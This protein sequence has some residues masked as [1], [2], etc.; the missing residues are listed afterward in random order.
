MKTPRLLPIPILLLVAFAILSVACGAIRQ[1]AQRQQKQN[2]LMQIGLA[3]QSYC[4]ANNK[5]PAGAD[6][7]SQY[8]GNAA[9]VQ[10]IKSGEYV[11]IWGVNLT[12]QKQF[13]QTGRSGTVLGYE[14][15]APTSG[16]VV[17][18]CD[19]FTQQMTAA[20]FNAKP[21]AKPGGGKK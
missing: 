12:D 9:V 3:Y 13:E 17:V 15:S 10:K 18:M 7:L 4:D 16:G 20:D 5:G 14:A 6:D 2:D 8:I 21:K 11:I 19:T 1:A